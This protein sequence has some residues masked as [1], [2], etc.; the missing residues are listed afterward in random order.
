[1]SS[2][3]YWYSPIY[4]KNDYGFFIE[5]DGNKYYLGF[6]YKNKKVVMVNITYQ[7]FK[8]LKEEWK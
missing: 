3:Q 2:N 1:M 8:V 5:K 4:E 7:T 6:K